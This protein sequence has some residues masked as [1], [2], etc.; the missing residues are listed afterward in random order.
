VIRGALRIELVLL[1]IPVINLIIASRE[2]LP[3]LG[4]NLD[5]LVKL[6]SDHDVEPL[7][8]RKSKSEAQSANV[9]FAYADLAR[10]LG[11]GHDPTRFD[12]PAFESF[13]NNVCLLCVGVAPYLQLPSRLPVCGQT[14]SNGKRSHSFVVTFDPVELKLVFEGKR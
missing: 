9:I 10:V 2:I 11:L 13:W 6:M 14:V 5:Q 3:H 12:D 7:L 4:G 8:V 1:Q